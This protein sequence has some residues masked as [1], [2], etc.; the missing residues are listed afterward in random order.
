MT[1]GSPPEVK[2]RELPGGGEGD[3]TILRGKGGS[4]RDAESLRS[5]LS[6]LLDRDRITPRALRPFPSGKDGLDRDLKTFRVQGSSLDAEAGW[7]R[8]L[9]QD[10]RDW[11]LEEGR[12]VHPV[13]Y[14]AFSAPVELA[15]EDGGRTALIIGGVALYTPLMLTA[16]QAP[17]YLDVGA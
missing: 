12:L 2:P 6:A 7:Y 14:V 3:L 9:A 10:P 1:R 15:D 8:T 11:D 16:R 13:R 4:G 5:D 17:L